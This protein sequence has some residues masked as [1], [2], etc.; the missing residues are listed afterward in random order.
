MLL[1]SSHTWRDHHRPEACLEV[2]GLSIENARL[3]QEVQKREKMLGDLLHQVVGAQEAER[4]RIARELHDTLAQGLA[5][6]VL[7]LEAL[8]YL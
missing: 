1:V 5:G 2:Y 4:Q 7:Q 3:Y 8:G 6:L